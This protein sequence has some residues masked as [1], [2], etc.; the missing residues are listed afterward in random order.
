MTP[1]PRFLGFC[2]AGALVATGARWAFT[3]L[4]GE[5]ALE[6]WA[7]RLGGHASYFGPQ[8]LAIPLGAAF[9]A[10]IAFPRGGR[11]HA[12]ALCAFGLLWFVAVTGLLVIRRP[13]HPAYS[14]LDV[15]LLLGGWSAVLWRAFARL[16]GERALPGALPAAMAG[17]AACRLA[18][19]LLSS[20]QL[21]ARLATADRFGIPGLSLAAIP[22]QAA[23]A[24]LAL[25]LGLWALAA[26]GGSLFEVPWAMAVALAGGLGLCVG[27]ADRTLLAEHWLW[28]A[29]SLL[30]AAGWSAWWGSR[31]ARGSAP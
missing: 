16:S 28:P 8:N 7:A 22:M 15:L 5:A 6:L 10:A 13:V 1:F 27:V 26:Y 3:A 9:G 24:A 25:L 19:A 20:A 4:V 17:L 14:L 29:T 31:L 30:G 2:I 23:A 11:G 12:A 18:E 21:H